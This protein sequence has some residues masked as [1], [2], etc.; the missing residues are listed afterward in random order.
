M[1]ERI[2]KYNL[3]IGC[4][5]CEAM[6]GKDKCKMEIN[7]KGFYEPMVSSPLDNLQSRMIAKVCPGIHVVGSPNKGSWGSMR[8]ICEGWSTDKRI[9][10]KAAAGGVVTSLAIYLIESRSVD[11]VLQVG[12]KDGS[13]LLNELKVSR[14]REDVIHNCQSRYA[15]ARVFPDIIEIL[16]STSENFAFIGKPCDIAGIKNLIAQRPKYSGRIKY[17]ISIFCAGMPSYNSTIKACTASGHTDEPDTIRYR[18]EG[19]PGEFFIGFKD[20]T[21]YQ[22]SYTESWRLYL[23]KSIGFRCKICPDGIGMLAD[24]SV[25][26]SWKTRNG[27]PDFT[28]ADGRCFCMLRNDRGVELIRGA[29]ENG[30]IEIEELDINKIKEQQAYQYSRRKLEGWRLIPVQIY[31]RS[32]LKFKGLGIWRQAITANPIIGLRNM[33][34]T[35][36]RLLRL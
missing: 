34:G 33:L 6:L 27:Y 4:G 35:A 5:L 13:C 14:L 28:E 30:Y 11:A 1:I 26:D 3:C 17:F 2:K 21:N 29:C 7:E 12:V 36:R 25:G 9:R 24:I 16:D 31:T 32:I 20:G 19:W 22:L 23:G 18:G 8:S 10:H 15:P